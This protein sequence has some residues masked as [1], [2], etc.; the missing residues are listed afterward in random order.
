MP[1]KLSSTIDGEIKV[2]LDKTKFTQY[3]SMNPALQ[4]TIKGK[5]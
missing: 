5:H 4:R 2:F 1:A 3:L